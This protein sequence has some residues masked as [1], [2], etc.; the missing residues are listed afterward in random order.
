M[1]NSAL[2]SLNTHNTHKPDREAILGFE[3]YQRDLIVK[4]RYQRSNA[5]LSS[6]RRGKITSFS[7]RS[8]KRLRH[9]LRNA[10]IK[11]QAFLTLTYP[12][13]YPTEPKSIKSHLNAFLQ[14]L[15][16]KNLKY[17]W[18]LEYQQR[19]A[20]HYHILLS[21]RL[22]KNEL[23]ER[24]YHIVGSGDIRHMRAGTQIKAINNPK[25]VYA[26]VSDYMKKSVQKT[27]PSDHTY[28][29]RWWGVSRG[30]LSYEFYYKIGPY[31]DLARLTRPIRAWYRSY[32]RRFGI[33]WQW[34]FY[35]FTTILDGVS[36]FR[37]LFRDAV[38]DNPCP[39]VRPVSV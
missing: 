23:S 7:R 9:F 18:I 5:V 25:Q 32:L 11:W 10:D 14:Y 22:D 4:L 34:R 13:N 15:R 28:S 39:I 19:G 26:Y 27:L 16:R 1:D 30:L 20:P 35:P 12:N 17:L 31:F 8:Y 24:W 2:I 21:Q 33:K 3:V 6:V 37:V 38:W 29:G 36:A